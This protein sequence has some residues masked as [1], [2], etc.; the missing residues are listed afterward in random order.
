MLSEI[1]KE[2]AVLEGIKKFFVK[3]HRAPTIR[4]LAD[5][6]QW[7]KSVT[8]K[9]ISILLRKGKITQEYDENN[10]AISKSLRVV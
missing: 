5:F 2:T 8:I 4:E 7:K 1:K 3:N 10:R 6:I 9:Y